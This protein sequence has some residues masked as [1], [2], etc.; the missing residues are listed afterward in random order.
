MLLIEAVEEIQEKSSNHLSMESIIRKINMSRDQLLRRFG[1]ETE[2]HRMDILEGEPQYPWEI[3]MG[4][5]KSVLVNGKNYPFSYLNDFTRSYYYYFLSGTIGIYP[6]PQESV[7]EGLTVFYD[8]TLAPLTVDSLEQEIGF[9]RDYDMLVVY[10]ALK[11]IDTGSLYTL[12]Y[13]ELL[14]DYLANN[15][16]PE[17]YQIRLERW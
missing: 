5:I 13:N 6:T 1:R 17:P 15:T 2:I 10:G 4:S 9:D 14:D 16:E 7:K 12:K 11:T 8:K 3:P